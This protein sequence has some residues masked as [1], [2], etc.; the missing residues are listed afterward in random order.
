MFSACS[1]LEF[2]DFGILDFV[3][4]V[5]YFGFGFWCLGLVQY[6]ILVAIGVSGEFSLPIGWVCWN[7][8]E[9]AVWS[10]FCLFNFEIWGFGFRVL[11]FLVFG[12]LEFEFRCLFCYKL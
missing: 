8:V 9:F 4:M 2:V 10:C 3:L 7:F 5:W 6:G 1:G 12:V 11:W